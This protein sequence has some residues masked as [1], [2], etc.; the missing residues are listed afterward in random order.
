MIEIVSEVV[1]SLLPRRWHRVV[2]W[3]VVALGIAAVAA[4]M[5]GI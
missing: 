4:A 3:T 2:L 1:Q 5:V